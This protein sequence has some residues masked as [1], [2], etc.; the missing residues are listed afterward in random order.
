MDKI[1]RDDEIWKQLANEHMI[2]EN[3][4]DASLVA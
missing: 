4:K 3:I 1:K 2:K